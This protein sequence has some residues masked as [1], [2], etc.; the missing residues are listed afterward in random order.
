[1]TFVAG[2]S[3]ALGTSIRWASHLKGGYRVPTTPH[4]AEFL[5]WTENDTVVDVPVKGTSTHFAAR[6]S[7]TLEGMGLR[8]EDAWGRFNYPREHSHGVVF[9]TTSSNPIKDWHQ[10]KWRVLEKR[11]VSEGVSVSFQTKDDL[12][13]LEKQL[14]ESRLVIGVDSGP[15]HLADYLG[16]MTLGLF[17][18]TSPR[19]HGT[20]NP[21]SLMINRHRG[22]EGIDID[23]VEHLTHGLLSGSTFKQ[24]VINV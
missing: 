18:Y 7:E 8:G 20:L 14:G 16:V 22:V 24:R 11:L 6:I 1:M 5:G 21:A 19:V 13:A 15:L 9:C 4:I 10:D 23:I 2:Q 3:R 17:G 12:R